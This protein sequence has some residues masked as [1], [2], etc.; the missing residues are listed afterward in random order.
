MSAA[1]VWL[2]LAC[3]HDPSCDVSPASTPDPDD[4]RVTQQAALAELDA[5]LAAIDEPATRGTSPR[6]VRSVA[7]VKGSDFGRA[8][9]RTGEGTSVEELVYIANFDD[10][11]GY[12]ILG[13][14]DRL[15]SV[16]AVTECGSLTAA[17][18]AAVA[19]GEYDDKEVPPV[20]PGIV[21]YT[22]GLGG[23]DGLGG[24]NGNLPFNPGDINTGDGYPAIRYTQ[25]GEWEQVSKK[26]PYLMMRWGQE[27]PY[28][29]F[30][31]EINGKHCPVGCVAV[32]IGQIAAANKYRQHLNNVTV[33]PSGNN[34]GGYSINWPLL[35]DQFQLIEED[36]NNN[37]PYF[38]LADSV[39]TE[40]IITAKLLRGIGAKLNMKYGESNSSATD[41]NAQ[42]VFR[43][44]GYLEVGFCK[45]N[46]E[47]ADEMLIKRKLPFYI[48]ADGGKNHA[49]VI[50]GVLSQKRRADV[51][52]SSGAHV[53]T[54]YES[55][56]LYHC[57]FGWAGNCDG[58]YY[59]NGI[60]DPSK[61]PIIKEQYSD[62]TKDLDSRY[63][64][65][66]MIPYKLQ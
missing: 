9:T 37:P 49:W 50:D 29:M 63:S 36:P 17:E 2:L 46:E 16:L 64:D 26:G 12:A 7:T 56:K 34:I 41:D 21:A 60:C 28:K 3:T 31:P 13:A 32:A 11:R 27:L 24:G 43:S 52:L 18:F 23:G 62:V 30:T 35:F 22:L 40:A 54:Y 25:Y 5:V 65:P 45:F 10:G 14:D 19:L 66:E 6:T 20:F 39:L 38:G 58:Y 8:A 42:R 15:P 57:N 51:Y 59:S 47:R 53:E 61:K 55:R 44:F 33:G 48:R 4:H 1:A